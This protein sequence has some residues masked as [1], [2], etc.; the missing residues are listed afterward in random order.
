[1]RV[2][3]AFGL[4]YLLVIG[5]VGSVASFVEIALVR[6]LLLGIAIVLWGIGCLAFVSVLAIER[7]DVS[8]YGSISC[9]ISGADSAYAPS[10]WSNVPPGE[11]CEYPSG[12]AG[13]GYGRVA[14]AAGLIALPLAALVGWP[15]R[16]TPDRVNV[17]VTV[18]A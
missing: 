10:H 14:I 7:S 15:R 8:R 2:D 16:R 6:R 5:V 13:P 11:V 1:V 17:G 3:V 18:S 12:N 4:G 9:P